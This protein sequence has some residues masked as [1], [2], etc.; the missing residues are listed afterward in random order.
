MYL[1]N[2]YDAKNTLHVTTW[3]WLLNCCAF[4]SIENNEKKTFFRPLDAASNDYSIP[5]SFSSQCQR[6]QNENHTNCRGQNEYYENCAVTTDTADNYPCT[7]GCQCFEG[8]ARNG[9][10]KCVLDRGEI[11]CG[12]NEFYS[13]CVNGGCG[14]RNCSQLRWPDL[15]IDIAEE[16]C[17]EGCVCKDGYLRNNDGDCVP[18]NYCPEKNNT[19]CRGQNEYYENCAVTTDTADNYPCTVGCQ[20]FEG[21]ARNGKGKCVLDRGEIACGPN[22]FYSDCVNGGC[23]RRNCSQLRWPD[24]CIDIAEEYCLEGCVCKDGYLRNNDGDCVPINYCPEKNNT[25]CRGQNEY[26]ENCAVTTDTA[27]NYPCTVGCQCFNDYVRISKGKCVRNI[28]VEGT[29]TPKTTTT[30]D[31]SPSNNKDAADIAADKI[32]Q[33][34][35]DFSG[36]FLKL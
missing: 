6:A 13:D 16:Y 29:T 14:R 28:G 34:N 11:A 18:I 27:D 7:V 19:N 32:W 3:D 10:G 1:L 15:C 17:L 23:G 2:R 12:P 25:N 33:A 35:A 20:C 4:L 36:Q 31:I 8:Y 22:E 5:K 24:L 26:Y 30:A 21:Y 9:K